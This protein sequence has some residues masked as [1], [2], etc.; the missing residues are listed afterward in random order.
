MI[1]STKTQ[2]Y[3]GLSMVRTKSITNK[4]TFK[5]LTE[6]DRG[7]IDVM[8]KHGKS[9]QEIADEIGC[10]KSTICRELKRGTVVQ[11]KS[12]RTYHEVY[13]PDV[14]QKVYENNRKACGAKL[15]LDTA[16]NFV[17]FVENKVL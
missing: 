7:K 15:K 3:G 9:L 14:G 17:Q 2:S 10:H 12:D 4:R 6:Y 16:I 1:K 5:H 11:M 8:H 13:F